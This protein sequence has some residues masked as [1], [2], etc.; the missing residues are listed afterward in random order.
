MNEYSDNLNELHDFDFKFLARQRVKTSDV[1]DE[2]LDGRIREEVA[3]D[4]TPTVR[5]TLETKAVRINVDTEGTVCM[6]VLLHLF[7]IPP[8]SLGVWFGITC[9]AAMVYLTAFGM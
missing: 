6:P 3:E 1:S 5:K 4:Y 9:F 2:Q 7:V 8:L